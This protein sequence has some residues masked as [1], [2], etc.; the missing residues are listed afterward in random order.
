MCTPSGARNR[1][2]PQVCPYCSGNIPVFHRPPRGDLAG[3]RDALSR[4]L[5]PP[6]RA[7]LWLDCP[8]PLRAGGSSCL[9]G[10]V[11]PLAGL[12]IVESKI[13][14]TPVAT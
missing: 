13:I 10:D 8:D 2:D 11:H 12:W 14:P 4:A 6:E 7:V 1:A 3:S 5:F 9:I